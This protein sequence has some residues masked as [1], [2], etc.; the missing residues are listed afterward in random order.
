MGKFKNQHQSASKILKPEK[1]KQLR[2]IK[3]R[4]E[5]RPKKN[6]AKA[7]YEY[8]NMTNEEVYD[9]IIM[10]SKYADHSR[11]AGPRGAG[12][13]QKLARARAR[14]APARRGAGVA[15]RGR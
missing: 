10:L 7:K 4:G 15:R 1:L 5:T 14:A 6:R 13:F 11:A 3:M 12:D 8:E 2:E 9:K